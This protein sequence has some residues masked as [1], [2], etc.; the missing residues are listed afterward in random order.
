MTTSQLKG[1]RSTL[2][3]APFI[4]IVGEAANGKEAVRKCKK[5]AP[6]VVLMDL[7][8]PEAGADLET[9]ELFGSC[10]HLNSTRSDNCKRTKGIISL[11]LYARE[12][13]AIACRPSPR[14]GS[15]H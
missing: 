7:N 1:L 12:A 9:T 15:R 6:D 3:D 11:K 13:Q 2:V 8:M 4:S 10:Q 14:A 5:L